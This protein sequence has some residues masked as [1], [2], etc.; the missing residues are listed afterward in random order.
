MVVSFVG[1][2]SSFDSGALIN[3]L[4][5]LEIQ[6]K[7]TPLEQKRSELEFE[8]S[9]LDT[10]SSSLGTVGTAIDWNEIVKGRTSLSPK[11]VT[12]TNNKDAN[13]NEY[14]GITTTD[15]AVA[16][17][18]T[19]DVNQLATNTNRTSSAAVAQALST[20]SSMSLATFKGGS[21]PNTGTVTINGET[22]TYTE[23]NATIRQSAS[24][25]TDPAAITETTVHTSANFKAGATLTGGTVNINGEQQTL[26]VSGSTTV[27]D[28]LDFFDSFSGVTASF[29]SGAIQ[30]SGVTSLS[31]G[32]S[33][34]LTALGLDTASI[35]S[36]TV[37]GDHNIT[38][39]TLEDYGI[40]D[41]SMTINGT[42]I[43]FNSYDTI[44]DLISAINSNS[45]TGVT[46]SY[47]SN[48][49]TLTRNDLGPDS[50]TI[51]PTAAG[52]VY[53]EF[54]LTSETIGVDADIQTA[55]LDFLEGF[56]SVSSATISGGKV[57]LAGTTTNI[58]GAGD[59]S[60]FISALGLDNATITGGA[61]TGLQNIYA[62][63]SSA[64]M[65]D[66]GVTS[67]DIIINGSTIEFEATDSITSLISKINNDANAKVSAA[68][69][70]LEGKLVLTNDDT[71]AL[72]L[73]ASSSSGNIVSIFNITGG[74]TLG[75]NAE[76]TISTINGGNTL[77]SN[78][79]SVSGLMT[80]VT[81]DLNEVTGTPVTVTIA[82][83]TAGVKEKFNEIIDATNS[84]IQTLQSDNT[85]FNRSLVSRI[86]STLTTIVGTNGSDPFRSLVEIGLESQLDGEGSFIGYTL[87][88]TV[89]DEAF[90]TNREALYSLLYGSSNVDSIYSTLSNGDQGI[91]TTFDELLDTYTDFDGVISQVQDSISSQINSVN[92]SIDRANDSV[93]SLER[94]LR[95]QFAQLDV[96]NAEYQQQQSAVAGLSSQLGQ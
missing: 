94:R 22:R 87:D 74:E 9:S 81:L 44:N 70:S 17:T 50:I 48:I 45:S 16:G 4:I 76:F 27:Q 12:S 52:S 10:I 85:S 20:T 71:G 96:I 46:A 59:S 54:G 65:S 89:F 15:D 40:T 83:D 42:T 8:R 30:L 58:G 7:V 80:G 60:N 19:I 36:S 39:A 1:L 47:D 91:F 56:A 31:N 23:P 13:D 3:Q 82:E 34:V 43:N 61:A 41:S 37:T 95:K 93:D 66:L 5:D 67:T 79:N 88:A 18:F 75:N 92:D 55:I 11:A 72:N 28:V 84:L 2:N 49:F 25:L 63:P 90:E 64:T 32:T 53:N 73:T 69:D 51:T 57:V 86:K 35:S 38:T 26:S 29:N 62:H 68:W 24:A 78:S 33:N 14:I 77:V 6:S 21:R